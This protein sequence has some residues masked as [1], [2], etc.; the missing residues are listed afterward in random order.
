MGIAEMRFN[1]YTYWREFPYY[2]RF[3]IFN[4][5]FSIFKERYYKYCLIVEILNFQVM[6]RFGMKR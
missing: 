6:I 2:F 4:I 1:F 5:A 3:S